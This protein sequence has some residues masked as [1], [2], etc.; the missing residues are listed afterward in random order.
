MVKIGNKGLSIE[1]D[2]EEDEMEGEE[3]GAAAADVP[4]MMLALS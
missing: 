4:A 2:T 3:A 1:A